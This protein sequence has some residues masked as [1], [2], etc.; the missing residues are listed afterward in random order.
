MEIGGG[1]YEGVYAN[2]LGI[3]LDFSAN[4]KLLKKESLVII[5]QPKIT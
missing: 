4:L 5:K 1:E 2:S 3:L